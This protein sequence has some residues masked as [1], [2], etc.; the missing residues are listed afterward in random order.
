[1]LKLGTEAFKAIN[2]QIGT[3]PQVVSP[4]SPPYAKEQQYLMSFWRKDQKDFQS[5]L[6]LY[7]RDRPNST[8][9]YYCRKIHNPSRSHA[10]S[11]HLCASVTFALWN[12][13]YFPYDIYFNKLQYIMKR[14]RLGLE[15]AAQL[16]ELSKTKT[17]RSLEDRKYTR[18]ISTLARI[19]NNK[20][21]LRTQDWTIIPSNPKPQ[22]PSW[23]NFQHC[24][25][26]GFFQHSAWQRCSCYH[27]TGCQ[28]CSCSSNE[29]E[30][31][32][33]CKLSHCNQSR[34]SRCS[35]VIRCKECPTEFQ[36]DS[37]KIGKDQW[38]LVFYGLEGS[39]EVRKSI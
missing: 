21:L 36:L 1:M 4:Y 7:D 30:R 26:W 39:W 25:H 38:A 32:I 35:D 2:K 34:C 17:T 15:T 19:R 5:F 23:W 9:C 31:L 10:G 22:L 24:P 29:I 20:L 8:Y 13:P 33:S 3:L 14:H 27:H 37:R 11:W 18:Q 6:Q 12:H 16:S 28:W